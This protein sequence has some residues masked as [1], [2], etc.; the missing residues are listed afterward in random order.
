MRPKQPHYLD[1]KLGGPTTPE[2]NLMVP[3]PVLAREWERVQ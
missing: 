2:W 1:R 3:A